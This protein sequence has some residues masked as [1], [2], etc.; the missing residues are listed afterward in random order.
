MCKN[1]GGRSTSSAVEK[2]GPD[3]SV[4]RLFDLARTVKG[5][6]EPEEGRRLYEVACEASRLGPCLEIGSYCGKSA[7]YLGAACKHNDTTLFSLDHHRGSEEHQ[8]GEL[9]FDPELFDPFHFRVDTLRHFRQTIFVAELENT[10]VP[11][12]T[13][14]AAAARHWT[15][16]L[17]LVFIDGGHAFE[18][19]LNDYQ[20][21]HRHILSGGFLIF[22]DV[23][24]DPA[25]GGQDPYL[26]HQMALSSGR[27]QPLAMTGSLG[28]LQRVD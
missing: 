25:D 17:S 4:D 13:T 18:T 19:V 11:L 1:N 8:P 22:H 14:S 5:F 16:P 7:L 21:W 28:V 23:F 9:Y 2:K 10:V 27:F 20:C 24:P 6:L 12:V 26:I 3:P 15:T